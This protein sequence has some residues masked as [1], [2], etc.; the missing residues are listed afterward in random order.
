M[1][2]FFLSPHYAPYIGGAETHTRTLAEAIAARGEQV[3][4]LSDRG[5]RDLPVSEWLNGV[6]V[7]RTSSAEVD[8][9]AAPAEGKVR[10]ESGFFD[11]LSDIEHLLER[12]EAGRPDIIHAQCQVSFL[13]GAILS[14]HYGCPLVVTAHET[15]PEHDGLG[16]ARSRFLSGLPQIDMYVAGSA[17]FQQQAVGWGL[18]AASIEVVESVPLQSG[19]PRT[20]PPFAN[21]RN[22]SIVSVGRFKPRKNQLGLLDALGRLKAAR[23]VTCVIAGSCDAGSFEYRDRVRAAASRLGPAV[24]VVEDASDDQIQ[25]L[26]RSADLVVQPATSEGLGLVALESLS[27]GTPVLV[28]PTSGGLEALGAYPDLLLDGFQPEQIAAGIERAVARPEQMI[29]SATAAA[30]AVRTRFDSVRSADRMISLYRRLLGQGPA[31]PDQPL[32]LGADR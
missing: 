32:V 19:S 12:Q 17:A 1:H 24:Q 22:V 29:A 9:A 3:T 25:T 11:L 18:P 10:W 4:V 21:P 13:F 31:C 28:T 16:M 8:P 20:S 7:L 15:T 14:E 6:R 27:L 23:P 2:V 26:L 5:R 30:A